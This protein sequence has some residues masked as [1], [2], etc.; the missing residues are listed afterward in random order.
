KSKLWLLASG[1][2]QPSMPPGKK[3]AA[4]DLDTLKQW[5]LAGAK[6][7]GGA[8]PAV[9]EDRAAT[10]AKM[11]ERPITAEEKNRWA[12]RPVKRPTVPEGVNAVD[13]FL[14]A[15]RKAKGLTASPEADRRNL[16]RRVYLDVI[17]I[18]P[19]P[20]EVAAFLNDK[21]A[22]AYEK[23]VDRLLASPHYGE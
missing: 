11:E 7:D 20:V 22:D 12:F 18:P 16:I 6:L 1:T 5:I 15:A 3:L 17:G 9:K 4:A 19:M 23:V 21:S 2:E 10:L 8:M 14:D 13:Y